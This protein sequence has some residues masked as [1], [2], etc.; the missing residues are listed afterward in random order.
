MN[1]FA[2]SS[3]KA[4]EIGPKVEEIVRGDVGAQAP[5]PYQIEGGDAGSM[6]AGKFLGDIASG[7]FGGKSDVLFNQH[8]DFT[9]PRPAHLQA[10]VNR[11]GLGA[12][13]GLLLFSTYLQK[14]VGGEIWLEDPKMFGKSKFKGDPA[15]ERLNGNGDL[16]KL[17]N[18]FA[19]TEAHSGALKLTIKRFCKIMPQPQGTLLV[20]G[21]LPR[22]IKM[23]FSA[24]TDAQDFFNL[25][26]M[27]EASL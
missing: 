21:T 2:Y 19:R 5:L 6:T 22:Q 9:Q 27:I 15:A 13:V 14:P 17:A 24:T 1:N 20:V 18:N 25:A 26:Q 10:T 12:Y 3:H 23:G 7:L 11:Q 16:V 8:F 4:E